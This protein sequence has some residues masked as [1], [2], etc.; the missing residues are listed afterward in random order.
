MFALRMD[1]RKLLRALESDVLHATAA[2][3]GSHLVRGNKRARIVEAEAYSADDPGSH[4]F[5]GRTPRNEIMFGPPGYAYVYFNYGVHWMLNVTAHPEGN[6]AAILIRAAE[7]I[8]GIEEMFSCRPR[9]KRP[10]DLL[11]GPGKLAAAFNISGAD[12]GINL[13]DPSSTLRLEPGA[14]PKKTLS[15][16]RIGLA[17]G[18][19]EELPWRFVDASALNWIS[20]PMR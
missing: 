4:A 20:R 11:S 16:A 2:I 5:R 15:G 12:Y 8:E 19:G 13:M 7:P 3:L 18:K 9:A 17:A 14:A 6:A 1:R 10:E